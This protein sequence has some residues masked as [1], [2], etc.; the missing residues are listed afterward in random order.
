MSD[1]S[2]RILF[3]IEKNDISYG[4]LSKITNIPKSALQRYATG[5]T[6]KIPLDR[7][8]KIADALNVS[9]SY[10]MGWEENE[11]PEIPEDQEMADLLNEF[12]DNPEL[13]ALFSLTK[14]ADPKEL[15]KYIDVIKTI[16]GY[17]NGEG[18]Y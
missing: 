11:S 8:E 5:E 15:R 1:I 12:R 2:N 10:L 3:L 6:E 4:E 13:R 9:A 7:L 17:D 14:K 18:N 16:K